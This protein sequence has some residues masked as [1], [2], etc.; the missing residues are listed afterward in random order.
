MNDLCIKGVNLFE[1]YSSPVEE[2][3]CKM[4]SERTSGFINRML[5]KLPE[6][7]IRGYNYCGPNTNLKSRLARGELGVNKLDYACMEHDIAYA[8]SDD[9]NSRCV[10][11]KVLILR[12]IRRIYEKDSQIGERFAALLISWL[13][14]V[15]LILCKIELFI[16]GVRKCLAMKLKKKS[17]ENI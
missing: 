9:L 13:I 6:M 8:E 17:R 1:N 11:D 2:A 7:H 16:V 15:K 4:S 5:E 10:A 14:S 12:A 3:V